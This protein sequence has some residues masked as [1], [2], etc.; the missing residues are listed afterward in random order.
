MKN[1]FSKLFVF[2]LFVSISSH[3]GPE[4]VPA[5]PCLNSILSVYNKFYVSLGAI[6]LTTVGKGDPKDNYEFALTERNLTGGP[7]IVYT[8][9]GNFTLSEEGCTKVNK[10]KNMEDFLREKYNKVINTGPDQVYGGPTER[11][12]FGELRNSA[13]KNCHRFDPWKSPLPIY[14][15]SKSAN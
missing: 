8:K 5:D 1:Q 14:P 15:T 2:G 3:A 13:I 9:K 11:K 12:A 4:V 6:G 7:T 10:S